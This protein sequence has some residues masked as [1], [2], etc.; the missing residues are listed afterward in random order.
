MLCD[1]TT[2]TTAL[3]LFKTLEEVAAANEIEKEPWIQRA[4]LDKERYENELLLFKK[5]ELNAFLQLLPK[6]E[7]LAD[8]GNDE[9]TYDVY[10]EGSF[11]DTRTSIL[12]RMYNFYIRW[13]KAIWSAS[14]SK[15]AKTTH[16]TF[17]FYEY[18]T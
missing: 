14:Q 3:F 11:K 9:D 5:K 15:H 6:D 10:A 1:C 7:Q 18:F 16:G 17:C 8:E 13:P 2:S 4:M 12:F